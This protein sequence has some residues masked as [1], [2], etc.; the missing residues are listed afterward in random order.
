MFRE[1]NSYPGNFFRPKPRFYPDAST[2]IGFGQILSGQM[3]DTSEKSVFSSE[4]SIFLLL[5]R[6]GAVAEGEYINSKRY[7]SP[8]PPPSPK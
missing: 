5:R 1:K 6:S 2:Y 7:F 3:E 4:I 8:P